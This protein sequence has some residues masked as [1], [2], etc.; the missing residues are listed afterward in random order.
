[1]A[2]NE[3]KKTQAL[4]ALMDSGTLTEAAEKAGI[5]RRTLYTYIRE[6]HDFAKAYRGLQEAAATAAAEA[7]ESRYKEASSVVKSIMD[8]ESQPAA[9]RLKA[10]QIILE[11]CDKASQKSNEIVGK[12]VTDTA[13]SL[14]DFNL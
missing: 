8:D 11:A 9:I 12:C 2:K 3:Q 6:D 13:P 14:F 10:A 5:S 7:A 4:A 1:M